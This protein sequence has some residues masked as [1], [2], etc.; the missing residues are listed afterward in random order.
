MSSKEQSVQQLLQDLQEVEPKA[1]AAVAGVVVATDG[2]AEHNVAVEV[3]KKL[4]EH[5][6]HKVEAS[7]QLA[8]LAR[9]STASQV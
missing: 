2:S 3:P 9:P 8:R 7:L 1:E 6:E 4:Q 5:K